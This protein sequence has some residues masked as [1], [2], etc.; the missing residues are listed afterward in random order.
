MDFRMQP[1]TEA[2]QRFVGLA[3]VHAKE[4]AEYADRHDREGTFPTEV[5][6]AM[7]ASGFLPATVPSEFGGFGMGSSYDLAVGLSRLLFPIVVLLGLSGIIV[8]ILNAYDHF[9]VP[10][11][12]PVAWTAR[13]P[14][15]RTCTSSSG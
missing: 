5:F 12:T 9:T 15:R 6:E 3:Q 7:K 14:S 10:A 1:R 4:A 8:G 11:L 2:G 13:P